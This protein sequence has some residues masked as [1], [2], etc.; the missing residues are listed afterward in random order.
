MLWIMSSTFNV[1]FHLQLL[2]GWMVLKS[3]S[4]PVVPTQLQATIT[5]A[6][7]QTWVIPVLMLKLELHVVLDTTM[8]DTCTSSK[9]QQVSTK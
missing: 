6:L 2:I 7:S 4:D 5:V 8:G 1:F 9:T 3:M